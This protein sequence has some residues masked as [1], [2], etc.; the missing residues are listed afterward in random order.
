[1][2]LG[3]RNQFE[4]ST[5]QTPGSPCDMVRKAYQPPGTVQ[6]QGDLAL[7]NTRNSGTAENQV[8]VEM[9]LA[10]NQK[11]VFQL[12]GQKQLC[13]KILLY[14]LFDLLGLA[15]RFGQVGQNIQMNA[16]APLIDRLC[17][18]CQTKKHEKNMLLH[19]L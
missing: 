3:R 14:W 4:E 7:T 5:L 9:S 15:V 16:S 6:D 18:D 2:P 13:S 12:A 10:L 17:R 8:P 19:Y 1:M 11:K